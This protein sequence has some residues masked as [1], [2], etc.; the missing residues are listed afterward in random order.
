MNTK[1]KKIAFVSG[2]SK[3]IGLAI[4]HKMLEQNYQ[5]I[6]CGR[7]LDD[8]N[9]AKTKNPELDEV[10]FIKTDLC[11]KQEL[12][13]L[14]ATIKKKYGHLNAAVN[15]AAVQI[16]AKGQ[17]TD[18][19]EDILRQNLDSDLWM[20]IMCIKK[21]LELMLSEGGSIVN[22]TSISGVIPT[23]DAAMYSAA[24][25]GLEGLTK[26]L[27]LELIDKNIRLNTVAPGPIM[28]PR[29]EKRVKK[30]DCEEIY[31]GVAARSP[32]KRFG[33]PEEVAAGVLWLLSDEASYVL[34]HTLIIDGG[35]SLRGNV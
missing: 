26:T 16:L 24:K 35:M 1:K 3:G 30:Q 15:N 6:T 31:A 25:Y 2:G 17:F 14:F 28:T 10:D 29:W 27:A 9:K 23:P 5:V 19:S 7:S 22:V 11:D 18:I 13:K 12:N 32:M 4:V 20:P 33:T 34:G 8:W 21:E